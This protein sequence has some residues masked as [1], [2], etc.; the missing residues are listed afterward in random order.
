MAVRTGSCMQN[1]RR[2][3][4]GR[5]GG[6]RNKLSNGGGELNSNNAP[7]LKIPPFRPDQSRQTRNILYALDIIQYESETMQNLGNRD[8]FEY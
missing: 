5:G 3:G 7:R 6:G 1:T 8:S 2:A 4:E